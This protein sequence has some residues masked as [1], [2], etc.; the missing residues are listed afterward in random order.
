MNK[1]SNKTKIIN[2]LT[3]HGECNNLYALKHGIWRLSDV[4]FRLR[5]EG[6]IIDGEFLKDKKGKQTKVFN[7][8]LPHLRKK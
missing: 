7:Y 6:W 8:Y 5:N 2:M 3:V 1:L 4:I